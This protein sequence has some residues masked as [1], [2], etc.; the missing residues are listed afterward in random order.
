LALTQTIEIILPNTIHGCKRKIFISL[1]TIAVFVGM[2][3]TLVYLSIYV[4]TYIIIYYRIKY[5]YYRLTAREIV[6][7]YKM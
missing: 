1:L 6:I 4:N 7:N 5:I 2:E 3:S